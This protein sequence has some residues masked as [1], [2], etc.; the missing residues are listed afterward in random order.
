M[1]ERRQVAIVGG[2]F[3]GIAAARALHGADV[4]VTVVD[5]MNHR[6]FQPLL[7]QVAAGILS[8]GEAAAPIR[9]MLARQANARVLM[10]EVDELDPERRELTLDRGERIAY[11]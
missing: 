5:R 4:D 3:G 6:V 2:G 7:Y 10:A 8:M 1:P 9:P 11:D